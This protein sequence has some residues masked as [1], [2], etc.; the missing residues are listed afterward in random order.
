[1]HR[2]PGFLH[3]WNLITRLTEHTWATRNGDDN[4]HIAEHHLQM[5]HQLDWD[6]KYSNIKWV[7]YGSVRINGSRYKWNKCHTFRPSLLLA[8]PFWDSWDYS[9]M[10]FLAFAPVATFSFYCFQSFSSDPRNSSIEASRMKTEHVKSV[11]QMAPN[12][13][14]LTAKAQRF[15]LYFQPSTSA[16]EHMRSA[17]QTKLNFIRK[18]WSSCDQI[19]LWAVEDEEFLLP[20]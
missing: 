7:V 14:V 18:T 15:V 12:N 3:W 4:N 16:F 20:G 13:S 11:K 8:D 2:L 10:I 5:K 19:L 1:M 6:S 17:Y 9:L